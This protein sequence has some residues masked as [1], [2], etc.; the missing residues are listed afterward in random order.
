MGRRPGGLINVRCGLCGAVERRSGGGGQ[1]RC[2]AC[3]AAGLRV[4]PSTRPDYL[5]KQAAQYEIA[6]AI[7]EG[8]LVHPTSLTCTD[9]D[10]PAVEYEHRDYNQPL[11]VDP[12]CRRCNLRRGPA[13]PLRG[14]LSAI[15]STGGVPYRL[16]SNAERMLVA[17][18]A[19]VPQ[20]DLPTRLTTEHWRA[21]LAHL[22][23]GA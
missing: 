5:G 23:A 12:I 13:I 10:S 17:M 9:C 7:R 21:I 1:Y 22:P 15:V 19:Q 18:G 14:S 8:R 11:C 2:G 6:L 20:L 4:R 16:R 3:K